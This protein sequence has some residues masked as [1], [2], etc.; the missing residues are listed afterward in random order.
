MWGGSGDAPL[1]L[2]SW[3][4]GDPILAQQLSHSCGSWSRSGSLVEAARNPFVETAL[5]YALSYVCAVKGDATFAPAVLTILADDDYYSQTD[6]G[7]RLGPFTDFGIPLTQVHKTGLGSSAA[8]VSSLV[9]AVLLHYSPPPLDLASD[10]VK[11]QMH[12]LAQAAHSA[13]QGKV[14]SGF[15]VASA[16]YGSC[17]YRRFSPSVLEA[18]GELGQPGFV[19]RLHAS[20][21][22][23]PP[24]PRWDTEI[25]KSAVA[26]PPGL[27]IVMCDVDCG[28]QTP[29]MVRQVLA[30]RTEKADESAKL[31][32]SLQ[33]KNE[34]LAHALVRAADRARDYQDLAPRIL[35]IRR[36]VQEESRQTGVPIEPPILTKLL[37]ECTA[38]EGVVGG[39]TP[40]AG[41]YDAVALLIEDKPDVVERLQD[42]LRRSWRSRSEPDA[43]IGQVRLLGVSGE[44][45]GLKREQH[46]RYQQ[47]TALEYQ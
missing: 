22:D 13:A 32:A 21:E 25:V 28:S 6:A 35:E 43:Q 17:I 23:R 33:A 24:S 9:A 26:I 29:G 41:G 2:S 15:D 47:W 19:E 12:N 36:L 18:V 5:S 42:L 16:V 38:L 44:M 31:W 45:E 7:K 11:M 20:V 27:R 37:D 8:L 3:A 10:R 39:V 30:W 4:T 1:A 46:D 14:G 34:A 40:G